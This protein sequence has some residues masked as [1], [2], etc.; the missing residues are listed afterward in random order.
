[1]WFLP[2]TVLVLFVSYQGQP[3]IIC[4]TPLAWGL[5]VPAGLNYVAFARGNPGRNAFLAGAILG[6]T[7]GLLLGILC[8]GVSVYSMPDDDPSTGR[9]TIRQISLIILGAG[10]LISVLL[11]G[12]TV[13]RAA[14]L[15][16]RGK[17]LTVIKAQ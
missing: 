17:G 7:L 15:Q 8:M 14:S 16:R 9:L 4:L 12:M 10:M 6:A 2:W 11:S 3:G 1:M 5:A 13:A